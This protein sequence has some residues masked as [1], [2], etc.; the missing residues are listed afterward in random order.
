MLDL[1]P[2]PPRCHWGESF[3][4]MK[5]KQ[6]SWEH[7]NNKIET[8]CEEVDLFSIFVTLRKKNWARFYIK[9]I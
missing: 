1:P 4:V 6:K 2:L 7:E 9:K 8:I 5:K 3:N